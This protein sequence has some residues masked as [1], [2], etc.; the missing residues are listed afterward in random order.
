[1]EN[2]QFYYPNVTTL[3][4]GISY[5]A[6]RPGQLFFNMALACCMDV[7]IVSVHVTGEPKHRSSELYSHDHCLLSKWKCCTWAH[8]HLCNNA[9][10]PISA[11]FL[12]HLVPWPSVDHQGKFYGHPGKPP[13]SGGL[14]ARGVNIAILDMSK[15][16]FSE[17]VH[18]M[19]KV[20]IINQYQSINLFRHTQTL[21]TKQ[22]T[23]KT[24][25]LCVTGST[26]GA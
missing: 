23:N 22:C 2:A 15:A 25:I 13:A 16:I 26:Q 3:R 8:N 12:R 24:F 18:D 20:T 6:D 9:T 10:Q 19:M 5:R 7:R 1:M 11:M 4:S 17:T 21:L 14:N